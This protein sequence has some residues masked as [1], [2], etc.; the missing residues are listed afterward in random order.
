MMINDGTCLLGMPPTL[1]SSAK[2]NSDDD[3]DDDDDDDGDDGVL[4]L[5]AFDSS[6]P[7]D[8]GSNAD[9]GTDSNTSTN[10][11]SSI[12]DSIVEVPGLPR[13]YNTTVQRLCS[14]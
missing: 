14:Y 10:A 13:Q 11:I 6:M 12:R 5:V 4:Y 8:D 9:D 7:F 3:D 2:E 1:A